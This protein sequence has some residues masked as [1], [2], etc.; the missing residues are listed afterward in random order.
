MFFR[1][2]RGGSEQARGKTFANRARQPDFL[3]VDQVEARPCDR[4]ASIVTFPP[5]CGCSLIA[6]ALGVE[7]RIEPG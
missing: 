4:E 5:N 7:F 2:R 6:A 3:R 1:H